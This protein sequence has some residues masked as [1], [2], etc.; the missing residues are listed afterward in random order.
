MFQ[1]IFRILWTIWC[2]PIFIIL[3]SIFTPALY[4]ML[5]FKQYDTGRKFPNWL[6]PLVLF[7]F[8]IKLKEH[9]RETID[10]NQQCIYVF[11][12]VS[13][14]DPFTSGAIV[15]PHAKFLAKAEILKYPGF[16][17]ILKHLHVPV[18]RY[19]KNDRDRSMRDLFKAIEEGF[20]L[21]MFPEGT[22]N[23]GPDLLKKFKK[24]A[25]Y[26][27]AKSGLPV[28]TCTVVN[29]HKRLSAHSILISPG[30]VDAYWDGPFYPTEEDEQDNEAYSDRIKKIMH[31]RMLS[32]NPSGQLY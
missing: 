13:N 15:P 18:Q 26:V 8:G 1:K 17:L 5:L 28:V 27:S 23:P 2:I 22:R 4:I 29:V 12:H 9:N 31:D 7:F 19:D 16:G 14:L 10:F 21:M 20:S 3:V 32:A 30:T 25:F 24:G 6:S 11:N